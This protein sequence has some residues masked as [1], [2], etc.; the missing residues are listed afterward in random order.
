MLFSTVAAPVCIPTNS[1]L[2]FPFL[3]IFV[4][5]CLLIYLWWHTD[6]NEVI[7]HCGYCYTIF[8]KNH[9]K[10]FFFLY[11]FTKFTK[12]QNYPFLKGVLEF[13]WDTVWAWCVWWR[14]ALWQLSLFFCSKEP[15]DC[16]TLLLLLLAIYIFLKFILS[17]TFSNYLT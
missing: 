17:S 10:V 11:V 4:T 12:H 15:L 7:F 3:H 14:V 6:R 9:C 5:T 13:F 16:L 2:G 1:V 8:Q